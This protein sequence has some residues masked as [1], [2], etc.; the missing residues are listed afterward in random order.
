VPNAVK[1]LQTSLDRGEVRLKAGDDDFGRWPATELFGGANELRNLAQSQS[2][3][4][5]PAHEAQLLE[6]LVVEQSLPTG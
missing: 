3:A 1:V 2:Q 4:L 6:C 5:H